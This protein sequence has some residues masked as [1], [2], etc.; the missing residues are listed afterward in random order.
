M[1]RDTTFSQRIG[2]DLIQAA[3]DELE[4]LETVSY[5]PN[6]CS[7]PVVRDAI[8]RY[9]LFWLPLALKSCSLRAAPL[10][11]AW[12]WHVHM[13][14]PYHYEQDCPNILNLVMDYSPI[15][16]TQILFFGLFRNCLNCDSLRWS[17]TYFKKRFGKKFITKEE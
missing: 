1:S 12:V 2:I 15:S 17:H 9:E 14:A 5:Y 4:F 10:D 8:R 11:I 7:G 3:K 13:L 6:L 16:S